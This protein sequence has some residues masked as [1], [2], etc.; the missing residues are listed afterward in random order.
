[1]ASSD[2]APSQAGFGQD[3]RGDRYQ[4]LHISPVPTY[5]FQVNKLFDVTHLFS[6][7]FH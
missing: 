4:Y 3:W 2:G 6:G 1:M 7:T 5:H